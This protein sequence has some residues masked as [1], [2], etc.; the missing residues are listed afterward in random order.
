ML[1]NISDQ[2]FLNEIQRRKAAIVLFY[3]TWCG[4]CARIKPTFETISKNDNREFVLVDISNEDSPLWDE[5]EIEVVPTI[6]QFKN[7]IP[8]KRISGVLTA[9]H[10]KKFLAGL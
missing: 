3:A 9:E 1:I 4:Y 10:L 8:G 5:F 2:T 7:G 6:I